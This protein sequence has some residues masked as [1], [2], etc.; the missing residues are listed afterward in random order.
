MQQYCLHRAPPRVGYAFDGTTKSG[1]ALPGDIALTWTARGRWSGAWEIALWLREQGAYGME[2]VR[3]QKE[4]VLAP[5][6][7]DGVGTAGGGAAAARTSNAWR[8][9]LKLPPVSSMTLTWQM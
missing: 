3:F 5:A 9:K 4:R 8:G 6:A 2:L 7:V 1:V